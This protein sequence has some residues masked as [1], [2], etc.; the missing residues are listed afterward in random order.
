MITRRLLTITLAVMIAGV[1][2]TASAG[3]EDEPGYL[4]LSFVDIPSDADEVQDIDLTAVLDDMADDAR[5]EGE[6]E[7]ADLLAMVRS[8]RVKFFSVGEDDAAVREDVERV[9]KMLD[10]EDWTRIIYIKD[11][12]ETVSVSTKS[13]EGTIVGLTVV[14]YEP[15]DS[16]GFVNVVG[17]MD[18]GRLLAMAQSVDM[19]ELEDYIDEYGGHHHRD[20]RVE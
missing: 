14:V 6:E 18:L 8:V 16:A 5:A 3:V 19:D 9:M 20:D 13:H 1:A 17:D 4:D 11:H 12:D 10:D 2:L 7:L 15:G